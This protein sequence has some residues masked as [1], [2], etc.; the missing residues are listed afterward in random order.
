[1]YGS[2]QKNVTNNSSDEM[3]IADAVNEYGIVQNNWE[4]HDN[5]GFKDDSYELRED[6]PVFDEISGFEQI[7][8]DNIGV[9]EEM[10][11]DLLSDVTLHSPKTSLQVENQTKLWTMGNSTTGKYIDLFEKA[12]FSSEDS[13]IVDVDANGIITAKSPGETEIKVIAE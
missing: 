3:Y 13:D 9:Q 4:T 2:V 12:E 1:K 10:N 11:E 7:P 6:S 5:L 8:F